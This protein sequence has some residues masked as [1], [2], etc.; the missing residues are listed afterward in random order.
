V[1]EIPLSL[2]GKYQQM[3]SGRK[4]LEGDRLQKGNG[5]KRNPEV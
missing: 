3:S 1:F 2:A 4:I 5:E